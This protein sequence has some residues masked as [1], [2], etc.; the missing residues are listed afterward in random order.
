M[1]IPILDRSRF[2]TTTFQS[3]CANCMALC[4]VA[5]VFDRGDMFDHDKFAGSACHLLK[6]HK[7]SIHTELNTRGYDGCIAYEC[8]G[9]GQKVS[10]FYDRDWREDPSQMKDILDVFAVMRDVQDLRQ[11]LIAARFFVLPP[12]VE[13]QRQ[14]WLEVLAHSIET[15][16]SVMDLDLQDLRKWIKGLAAHI[17]R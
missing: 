10:A 16:D 2:Q 11:M 13:D 7:C 3:D 17:V 12:E 15:R 8:A 1:Q 14:N 4:C 6:G 9:A 5:L